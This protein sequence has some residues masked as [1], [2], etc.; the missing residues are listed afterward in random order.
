[1]RKILA[2]VVLALAVT[3]APAHDFWILPS[4]FLPAP[5]LLVSARLFVGIAWQGE[6]VPR[7]NDRIVRFALVAPTGEEQPLVGVD[8]T[9]P[10]GFARPQAPGIQTMVYQ[11]NAAVIDLPADKIETYIEEEGLEPFLVLK[12]EEKAAGIKDHYARCAKSLLLVGKADK[13][14]KG[15][16]RKLGLPLELIADVNPYLLAKGRKLP[17][18]LLRDGKPIANVLVTAIQRDAPAQSKVSART[19][20]KGKVVLA[21]SR[22]GVWLVKAV[23]IA[24]A[25]APGEWNSLWASLTFEVPAGP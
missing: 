16:D 14:T 24:R 12:D 10:A 6:L 4:S 19:D 23:H 25:D 15:F 21:L 8:G 18:R 1:M 5:G 22:P 11:T 17:L 3:A 20:A 7:S 13:T 2:L 9:D